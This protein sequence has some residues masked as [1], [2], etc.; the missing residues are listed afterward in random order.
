[1]AR[2]LNK[3]DAPHSFGGD[4]TT[5]KLQR[6][7]AYL[8]EY[9]KILKS[10]AYTTIYIDAFAGT[11]SVSLGG[12]DS[13]PSLPAFADPEAERFV[14][15]SAAQALDIDPP[16]ARYIF[17]ERSADR[18]AE[19]NE[20]P[21]RYT[22]LD[23]RIQVENRDA[24]EFLVEFCQR[25]NWAT[26]R[27]ALFLD[28]YGM[29]VDW[30]TIQAIAATRAID[31]WYLFPL[32]VAVNRLLTKDEVIPDPWK[33]SLNRLFGAADWYDTFYRQ[34]REVS[35]FGPL[36]STEKV[37]DFEAISQ[38]FVTRLKTVF[39]GVAENPLQLLNS[40]GNPLF[41]LCFASAN[42]NAK[43]AVKIARYI[44][45]NPPRGGRRR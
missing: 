7:R 3:P 40:T 35:L 32:G 33:Q 39:P 22:H 9:M 16:F 4:W 37:A 25:T 31:M 36:E 18:C 13:N 19:L 41:L 23:G 14:Q 11:G 45:G 26:S 24:N 15:G 10:R 42:S 8:T 43:A 12:S 21:K 28:P 1:M 5:E 20:L 27:A 6:V 38:Y 30:T 2:K 34:R 17:V 44:L 29:A